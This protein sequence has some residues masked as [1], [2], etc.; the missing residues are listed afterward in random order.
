[1]KVLVTGIAGFIGFHVGQRFLRDG[2]DVVGVDNV[3]AYYDPELKRARLRELVRVASGGPAA[4]T[5]HELD[6]CDAVVLADALRDDSFDAVIHLAAQPGIRYSLEAPQSYI[7]NNI[8]GFGNVLELCRHSKAPHLVF[9]SSS[10]VYG[11]NATLPYSEHDTAD[12]PLQ[13]YAATKRAGEL[14]AHSYAHLYSIP[15]TCLRLF[16]VYGP[17]GRPDMSL[18]TFVERILD[19]QPIHL[20]NHGHHA[21]DFTYV[22]DVVQSILLVVARPPTRSAAWAPLTPDP[23]IG[24]GPFRILNIGG[25]QLVTLDEFVDTIEAAL[26]KKAVRELVPGST[27]EMRNTLA[28]TED[29]ERLIGIKP[30]T[31]IR[32]GVKRF[33]EW[34]LTYFKS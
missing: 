25:G 26:G 10:S 15:T 28:A 6:I 17:W 30:Q 22:D 2:H 19:G 18:F 20:S 3:N 7:Q 14:I 31:T 16:T 5:F 34:Y 12:H 24:D 27:A 8:V 11:A 23:A 13:M 33:V 29:Q 1:M 21:R 4:Y 32:D 9:A